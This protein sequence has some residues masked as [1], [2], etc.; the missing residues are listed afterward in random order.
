MFSCFS[1]LFFFL[2]PP[3]FMVLFV[4]CFQGTTKK[5]KKKRLEEEVAPRFCGATWVSNVLNQKVVNFFY[6]IKVNL[7]PF[8]SDHVKRSRIVSTFFFFGWGFLKGKL[9][10]LFLV[11]LLTQLL[12]NSNNCFSN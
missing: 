2:F 7:L 12:Y 5:K 8:V 1:W 11:Q 3:F 10:A 9:I 6:R 4:V